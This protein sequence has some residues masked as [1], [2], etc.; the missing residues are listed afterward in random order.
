MENVVIFYD[1][2][3]YFMAIW[4][5]VWQFGICSLW[6]L[7]IFLPFWYVWPEKNL[8]TMDFEIDASEKIVLLTFDICTLLAAY[9]ILLCN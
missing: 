5:D 8:A 9:R 7:G 3:E 2:L 1:H 4:H 6:S